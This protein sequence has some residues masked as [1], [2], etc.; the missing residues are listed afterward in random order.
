MKREQLVIYVLSD[1]IG[2]TAERVL[3]AAGSQFEDEHNI[4]YRKFSYV[5]K[6]HTL[7]HLLL[8]AE[9]EADIVAYTFVL[10]EL[11]EYLRENKHKYTVKILDLITH[12]I[13]AIVEITSW[14]PKYQAGLFHALDE[15]YFKQIEAVEFAVKYDDGKDPR[16]LLKAEIVLIGV[17]RTSKTPLSMY[18]AHRG[19]KV[20]NV[21]LMPEVKPPKELFQ[22]E[23]GKIIGLIISPESLVEIRNERLKILGFNRGASYAARDRVEAELRY[24]LD[25]MNRLDCPIIDVTQT[26]I[27]ETANKIIEMMKNNN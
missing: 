16:G 24:A 5:H 2:E 11:N 12:V 19:Y 1:S 6:V 23:S 17:S 20:A 8:E 3:Q 13:D 14:Q 27:E 22:V 21:P 9:R 26:A 7:E 10:P 4:V 18:L 15:D 25:I